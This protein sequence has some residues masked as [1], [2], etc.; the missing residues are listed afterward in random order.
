[1]SLTYRANLTRYHE[2]AMYI[3]VALSFLAVAFKSLAVPVLVLSVVGYLVSI[4]W[5]QRGLSGWVPQWIWNGLVLITLLVTGAQLYMSDDSSAI[6]LGVQFITLLMM[7][8]LFSRQGDRDEWQIYA[9]TF[10]LMAAGTAVNEDLVYGLLFALYVVVGTFGLALFHLVVEERRRERR[11]ARLPMGRVYAAILA[12][13]AGA[14]FM[15]SVSIFFVFPRV[16]LGFFATKKRD[17]ASMTGFSEKVELGSHGVIRDNPQVALRVYFKNGKM[18]QEAGSFHWRMRS[19]DRYDGEAWTRTLRQK[20]HHIQRNKAFEFQLSDA[21]YNPVMRGVIGA[22]AEEQVTIYME[23]LGTDHMPT[24]WPALGIDANPGALRVPFNPRHV[25]LYLDAYNDLHFNMRNELGLPYTMRFG[26]APDTKTLRG[27]SDGSASA[28]TRAL[29]EARAR[30]RRR[31]VGDAYL[32]VPEG[33]E[34]TK[35]LAKRVAGEAKDPYSKAQAIIA[36]LEANYRYTTDL[37]PTTGQ[38]VEAF[39]FDTRR[40]HCEFFASSMVLM[41]RSVGVEA[42]LVNGFLGGT[43][44]ELGG[45]MAVRQGD[46]H[47]W[48]EIYIPELGWVPLDP[49]PSSGAPAINPAQQWLYNAYDSARMTWMRWVVEYDLERQIKAAQQL[50]NALSPRSSFFKNNSKDRDGDKDDE[51]KAAQ[52]NAAALRFWI[53]ILGY[54]GLLVGGYVQ[55]SKARGRPWLVA[56]ALWLGWSLALVGWMTWFVGSWGAASWGGVSALLMSGL[57]ALL[58]QAM[59]KGRSGARVASDLFAQLEREAR[60]AGVERPADQGPDRFLGALSSRFPAASRE[61]TMF[62]ARYL[63]ARFGEGDLS[64]EEERALRKMIRRIGQL[65]RG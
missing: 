45:Y 25:A 39:L 65:M 32:H 16:G 48:V 22:R 27:Y 61:L 18:P 56:G 33:F 5:H 37:P 19:F 26:Q 3:V 8:K 64:G 2:R 1:M 4:F 15:S 51:Q 43:W 20:R 57:G 53:F 62:R 31:R 50:G 12:L 60:R 41:A 13:L 29:V 34:R 6:D 59:R 40:G 17:G 44:N 11:A 9:L 30:A 58:G 36:Y 24:L 47:S 23:P 52:L 14:V 35:A 63:R 54:G 46:A 49:T 7:I 38:P 28:D 42:R 10:L 55:A 21:L